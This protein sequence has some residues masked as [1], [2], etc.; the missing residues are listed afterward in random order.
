MIERTLIIIK[1]DG[2]RRNLVGE[3]IGRYEQGGLRVVALKMLKASQ[4]L[5]SRHYTEDEGYLISLGKKSEK[6]GDAV[7]DYRKHGLMIVHG[8]RKYM[9][10]GPVVAIVLEGENAI[11][12]A[13]EIT[14]YTDPSAAD[15]GTIRGDFGED[16][17]LEANRENRPVRN[18]IHASGNPDEAEHEISL[19]FP[20][21]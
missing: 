7:K 14:G 19:W 4:E 21:I 5:I 18:L 12:R 16:N 6:A 17:I 15:K 13:R 20:E 3:V 10:E 1:P 2:V 9:T 11:K 8:L